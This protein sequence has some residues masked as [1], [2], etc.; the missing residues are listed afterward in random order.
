MTDSEQPLT[1]RAAREAAEREAAGLPPLTPEEAAAA[2]AAHAAEDAE[3]DAAARASETSDSAPDAAAPD[4]AAPAPVDATA[5]AATP[6]P[7]GTAD[8]AADGAAD[9]AADVAAEPADST[10]PYPPLGWHDYPPA[11]VQPHTTTPQSAEPVSAEPVSAEPSSAEPV[12]PEPLVEPEPEP[13]ATWNAEAAKPELPTELTPADLTSTDLAPIPPTPADPAPVEATPMDPTPTV[14]YTPEPDDLA[15]AVPPEAAVQIDPSPTV[16]YTP[17]AE[18]LAA[19][20]RAHEAA[21][22]SVPMTAVP[23]PAAPVDPAPTVAFTADDAPTSIWKPDP[24]PYQPP[25]VSDAARTTLLAPSPADPFFSDDNEMPVQQPGF[26]SRNR[27]VVVP[28]ALA[29]AFVLL[30]TGAVFAGIAAGNPAAASNP[31]QGAPDATARVVPESI[32]AATQINTC[33]I[34]SLVGDDN[35]KTIYMSVVNTADGDSLYDKRGE[36]AKSPAGGMQAVTAAAAISALGPDYT[37]S[38]RV[39]DNNTPGSIVLVGGGDATLSQLPSGEDGVYAGAPKLADL[40]TATLASYDAAHPDVPIT[41]VVLDSSYWD[42]A[43]RWDASWDR[44][45]QTDGTQSEV[46]AL[47]VDGDREDPKQQVSP[48]STDPITH[49]GEA[50]VEAL[51]L[52]SVALREGTAE[53]GAPVLAEVKSAPMSTLVTQMLQQNDNT[54]AEML[55]RV[56]SKESNLDGSSASLQQAIPDELTKLGLDTDGIVVRDGS[57]LSA[58]DTIS[59][60]AMAKLMVMLTTNDEL[61]AV[62]AAFPVAGKTGDLASGFTGDNDGAVDKLSAKSGAPNASGR[63]SLSGYTTARD[64]STIAFALYAI[65]DTVSDDTTLALQ[66]LAAGIYTCGENLSTH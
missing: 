35:L 8:S 31:D 23:T 29:L 65:G 66:N 4:A 60:R 16:A 45:A 51:G 62:S 27:R 2:N 38:T 11:A 55:A 53:N 44:S 49:A 41:E 32:P 22:P 13:H 3:A 47:Q 42:S 24:I 58:D 52:G 6:A 30:G 33:S 61:A 14:A 21:V 18:D 36:E 7:A 34:T 57:G 54:L 12:S 46:T 37:L 40:A 28:V 63:Y 5:T 26:F 17:S 15:A 56:V 19:A 43:D 48:R 9:S 50:F 39:L 1:R 25:P 59:A 64:G 10:L 20:V